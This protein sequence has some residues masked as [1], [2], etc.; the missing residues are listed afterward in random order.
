MDWLKV[1]EEVFQLVIFP[2]L[3]VLGAYGAAFVKEKIA[4]AKEKTK[5][6]KAEKYL[7][8]AEVA[9]ISAIEATNQTY[10]NAL[11]AENKFDADAQ[12]VALEKTVKAV[13]DILSAEAKVCLE[14]AIG[15]LTAYISTRTESIIASQKKTTTSTSTTVGY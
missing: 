14:T 4:E 1:L 7:D 9:I 10:V 6:E 13:K 3:G 11:K 15:D 8:I 12:K 5:M 2:V